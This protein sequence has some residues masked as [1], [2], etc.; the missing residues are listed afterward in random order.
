MYFNFD[1]D[2]T[3]GKETYFTDSLKELLKDRHMSL[4]ELSRETGISL[5]TVYSWRQGRVPQ[6]RNLQ[7]LCNYLGVSTKELLF[8]KGPGS[9]GNPD[10]SGN[11][12]TGESSEQNEDI[13]ERLNARNRRLYS[14]AVRLSSLSSSQLLA[15]ML[16]E[17]SALSD[18][19]R[20]SLVS[21]A[22]RLN[23]TK[24]E[25]PKQTD[26]NDD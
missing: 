4:A 23:Q 22:H 26:E 18:E 13:E 21:L 7:K 6:G 24:K 10:T 11:Q 14:Y 1:D 8:G 2:K 5:A 20:V 12:I 9:E 17:W 3:S 19:D 16:D 25:E 15:S